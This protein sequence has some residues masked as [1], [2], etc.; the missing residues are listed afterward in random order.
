MSA[1]LILLIN[2]TYHDGTPEHAPVKFLRYTATLAVLLL[3]PLAL[4][5]G[6]ALTQR[7][8]Q[9]GWTVNMIEIAACLIVA[10]CY[11]AGYFYAAIVSGPWLKKLETTNIATGFRHPDCTGRIVHAHCRSGAARGERSGR[12][13]E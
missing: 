10:L 4:L 7:V 3:L 9:H 13:P 6:F 11:G 5:A 2:V 8:H 12:A 1:W